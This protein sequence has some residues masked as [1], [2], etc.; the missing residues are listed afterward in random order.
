MHFSGEHWMTLPRSSPRTAASLLLGL[1]VALLATVTPAGAQTTRYQNLVNTRFATVSSGPQSSVIVD[2]PSRAGADEE[3]R[4]IRD[5]ARAQWAADAKGLS[6][7][8]AAL[9]RSGALR[10][11]AANAV[12]PISAIVAVRKSGRLV[13]PPLRRTRALGGGNLTFVVKSEGADGFNAVDRQFLNAFIAR[14]YPRIVE[15][16]GQPAWS[17][18]V[19]VVNAG[20]LENST[21]SQVKR[22]A[23]GAYDVSNA[24][25][26]LPIFDNVDSFAHALLLNMVHAFHGPAVFQYDAWEQGFARAAAAAIISRFN[27]DLGF[28]DATANFYYALLPYYDLLNQPALGN[29]TFFPPSQANVELHGR[30]TVGK[31]LLPRLGM[32]GAA[33]LKV[34]VEDPLFFRRFNEAYYAQFDQNAQPSLA[35]NVPA[36]RAIA[37]PLLPGGVEGIPWEAWYEQQYILDTSVSVGQKLYAFVLPEALDEQGGQSSSVTLVYFRGEPNGDE[38]LLNGTGYATYFDAQ[39]ARIPSLGP[40][41]EQTQIG[42]NE[43]AGEGFLTTLAFPTPGFDAS[44]I[45]MDFHVG[46]SNVTARTYLPSGFSGDFQAVALGPNARGNA[47]I[48]QTTVIGSTQTR[49]KTQALDNA[50]LG[51]GLGTGPFD[52][53]KTVVTINNSGVT[54][55]YQFN[56]GFGQYYAVIRRGASGGGVVTVNKAFAVRPTPHLVS[57]PVR[58]LEQSVDVALGL[59]VSEFLLSYWDPARALYETVVPNQPTVAPLQPGRAY[60]LKLSPSAGQTQMAVTMTGIAPA[61]DTD[62]TISCPYGWNLIGSPF[63]QGI[64]VS[65]IL[66]QYLQNDAISW[67]EAVGRFLVAKNPFAFNADTGA[68]EET[69]LLDGAAWSGYW[70]RVL[71]PGGVNLILPAPDSPITRAASPFRYVGRASATVA[72]RPDWSVRLRAQTAAAREGQV[73]GT[74]ASAA[75]G[76]ARGAGTGFDNR[77]DLEAPPAIVPGVAVHFPHTDWG[78]AAGGRYV[79]DFRGVGTG[80]R[81][82]WDV[83]VD[84]PTDGPV[85]VSWDGL[86]TVPR[87]TNLVLVDKETGDRTPLRSRSAYTFSATGGKTRAFQIVA[88]PGRSTPLMING[89]S[90][91]TTRAQG[92]SG[93]SVSYVVTDPDA[94]VTVELTT[95]GGRVI[96]RMNGGRAEAGGR[97]TARWDGRSQEGAALAPGAYMLNITARSAEGGTVRQSRP[98]MLLQ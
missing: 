42:A 21:I 63:S 53:C 31:M 38:T 88:E 9:R 86:G 66:V 56:T 89:V 93:M 57:L 54:E 97:R 14:L 92:T 8:L 95:I 44:R 49:T 85:T 47:T 58:P 65:K 1:F 32:S 61:S 2:V 80:G 23:F 18:T 13:M 15:V 74:V 81:A 26:L 69:N 29:S 48:T 90:V 98:V 96:R 78:K 67:D 10:G 7:Q 72:A 84:T 79:A 91:S 73:L 55:T 40:A 94:D 71:V 19:E 3:R 35:G 59:S 36:L 76:S 28:Q 46:N 50:A 16:Y 75:F 34:F 82:A 45:T 68:Y 51:V 20:N 41:S 27:V 39:N 17:G 70:L 52:L 30:F 24:R 25:I 60:W 87:G 5:T 6:T 64:D 77:Y 83:R 33:W 37:A 11:R 22:A 4:L 62:F 43:S 12:V